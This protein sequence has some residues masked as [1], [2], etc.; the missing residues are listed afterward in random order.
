V[1]VAAT[2]RRDPW[3]RRVGIEVRNV[4]IAVLLSAVVLA[5]TVGAVIWLTSLFVH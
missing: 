3:H 1:V 4:A 5:A 2:S